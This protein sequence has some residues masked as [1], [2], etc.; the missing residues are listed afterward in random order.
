MNNIINQRFTIS[1]HQKL[2]SLNL[3]ML[4]QMIEESKIN[5]MIE[6]SVKQLEKGI[7]VEIRSDILDSYIKKILF[8]IEKV[9]DNLKDFMLSGN[10]FSVIYNLIF[11]DMFGS[12]NQLKVELISKFNCEEVKITTIDKNILD[13]Y[14]K[15]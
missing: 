4:K 5:K 6:T 3:H 13:G 10:I 15:I 2:L 11:N 12:L 1:K 9:E 8:N 14:F 7:Y